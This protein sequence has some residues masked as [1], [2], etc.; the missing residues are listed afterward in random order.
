MIPH[1]APGPAFAALCPHA[2]IGPEIAPRRRSRRSEIDAADDRLLG[3]IAV[4]E[5]VALRYTT[6]AQDEE[7]IRD[8]ERE[9][10][11]LLDQHHRDAARLQPV[12]DRAD[13]VD[14]GRGEPARRLVEE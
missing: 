7:A 6:I 8:G 12:H 2:S 9:L 13:F 10:Q 1:L 14:E 11:V 5:V 3:D 4:A